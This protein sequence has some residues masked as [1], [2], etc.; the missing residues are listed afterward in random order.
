MTAFFNEMGIPRSVYREF[1]SRRHIE[2]V[3]GCIENENSPANTRSQSEKYRR[4]KRMAADEYTQECAKYAEKSGK[5]MKFIINLIK[6]K[7]FLMVYMMGVV[8]AFSRSR[9]PRMFARLKYTSR[10]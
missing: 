6:K 7:K 10:A 9:L 5:K 8:M 2:R 1:L 3:V 4:V